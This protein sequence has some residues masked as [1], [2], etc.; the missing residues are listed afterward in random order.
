MPVIRKKNPSLHSVLLEPIMMQ[1]AEYGSLHTRYATG[2]L[3][4]CSLEETCSDI[5]SG[6]PG[7]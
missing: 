6:R 2:G 1:A 3:C 7:L 4:R 5:G